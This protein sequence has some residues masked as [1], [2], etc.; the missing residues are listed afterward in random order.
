MTVRSKTHTFQADGSL[1][2]ESTSVVPEFRSMRRKAVLAR[3][4]RFIGDSDVSDQR[5]Q[6]L[7]EEVRR[8]GEPQPGSPRYDVQQACEH[9]L[10]E[11]CR[12]MGT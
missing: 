5:L 11:R 3:G 6:S 10:A 7:L 2:A 9:L 8:N 1:R 4:M 12:D